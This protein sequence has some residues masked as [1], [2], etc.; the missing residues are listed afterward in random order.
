MAARYAL[1]GV[2]GLALVAAVASGTT[3]LLVRSLL[4][5]QPVLAVGM[6]GRGGYAAGNG[7]G[8]LVEGKEIALPK[9][10]TNL[11]DPGAAVD[12]T[13]VLVVRSDKDA[14]RVERAKN[15]LRDGILGLLRTRRAA[16]LTGPGGKDRLAELVL[17]RANELLGSG[18]VTRVLVPDMVTQP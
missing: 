11:A 8:G 13:F 15:Q 7:M 5:T 9:F 3:L 2:A 4:Q 12:V 18:T 14:A 10:V 17:Q 16:D 1:A 6:P